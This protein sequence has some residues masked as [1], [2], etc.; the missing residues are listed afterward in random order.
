MNYFTYIKEKL[1][2]LINEMDHYHWL[3][4]RNAEKDFSRIKKW[5]FGE[6]MRFIISM[7]GKSLKDELL[8]HFNFSVDTPTN[9]SFN[10]RRAQILPEA[11]ELLHL[12]KNYSVDIACWPVTDQ[13]CVLHTIRRM[14]QHIFNPHQTQKALIKCI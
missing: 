13:I 9:S 1:V 10:Q 6:I 3:F 11:F 8:E 14:K 5:S 12:E 7:E 2:S 4:T